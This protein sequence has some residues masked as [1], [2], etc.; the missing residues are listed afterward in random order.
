MKHNKKIETLQKDQ[1]DQ[2]GQIL[3]QYLAI[4]KY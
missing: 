2:M 4:D 3:R 1:M